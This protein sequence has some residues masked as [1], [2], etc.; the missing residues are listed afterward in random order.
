[1][2]TARCFCKFCRSTGVHAQRKSFRLGMEWRMQGF[3]ASQPFVLLD[4]ARE[5]MAAAT[6]RLF[7]RPRGVISASSPDPVANALEQLRLAIALG[8]TEIGRETCRE[9]GWKYV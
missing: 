2:T 5:G 8:R 7:T 4:D 1:M 6:A 3:D 9:R